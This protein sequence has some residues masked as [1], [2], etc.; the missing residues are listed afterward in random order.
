MHN[1][2]LFSLGIITCLFVGCAHPTPTE[3]IKQTIHIPVGS[4][5]WINNVTVGDV[6]PCDASNK[7]C[8]TFTGIKNNFAKTIGNDLIHY[9]PALNNYVATTT[10]PVAANA[11]P[12]TA[13]TNFSTQ[14]Q[15]QHATGGSITLTASNCKHTNN[16]VRVSLAFGDYHRVNPFEP[17]EGGILQQT[18]LGTIVPD[19]KAKDYTLPLS[20]TNV[21]LINNFINHYINH[22][23]PNTQKN[24]GLY[25]VF[26]LL[27]EQQPP[28]EQEGDSDSCLQINYNNNDKLI[29]HVESEPEPLN[30]H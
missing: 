18:T 29:I 7:Q 22:P 15:N 19:Q 6:S 11:P 13:I 3:P 26:E 25:L 4:P 8:K 28:N 24:V 5:S 1:S 17:L 12:V 23:S 2:S 14:L 27:A 20:S 21:E 10:L 16:H 30:K 9:Y